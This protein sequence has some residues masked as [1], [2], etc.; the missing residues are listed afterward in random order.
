MLLILLFIIIVIASLIFISGIIYRRKSGVCTCQNRLDGKTIIITG[1]SAGIGKEAAFDLANRGAR[2]IL[3]CRNL[4]KAEKV[5]D[6]IVNS[7]GNKNVVCRHLELSDL[8]SVRKFVEETL[9]EETRLD[10]LI[11][12]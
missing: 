12:L 10:V 3:A 1:A 2:V 8:N 5:K 9:K 4:E 11:Y 6:W 7:T